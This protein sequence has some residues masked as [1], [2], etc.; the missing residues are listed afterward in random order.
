M[1][2]SLRRMYKTLVTLDMA[3]PTKKEIHFISF[4]IDLHIEDIVLSSHT[5]S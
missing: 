4:Q 5:W 2:F 1:Q 3:S